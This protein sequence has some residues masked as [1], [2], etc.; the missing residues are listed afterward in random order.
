MTNNYTKNTTRERGK[1]KEMNCNPP[2]RKNNKSHEKKL[3]LNAHR[4]KT[5]FPTSIIQYRVYYISLNWR[6]KS[7][8]WTIDHWIPPNNVIFLISLFLFLATFLSN[9]VFFHAFFLWGRWLF[10]FLSNSNIFLWEKEK[11]SNIFLK[12]KPLGR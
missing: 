9:S 7:F 8:M 5:N 4:Q 11:I 12:L 1:K 2:K 3:V 10:L 6:K